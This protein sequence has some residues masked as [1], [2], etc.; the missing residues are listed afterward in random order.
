MGYLKMRSSHAS[1]RILKAYTKAT[2]RCSH[3]SIQMI[4]TITY[5]LKTESLKQLAVK[6]VSRIIHSK[7][8][9]RGKEP[10]IACIQ[11]IGQ[12]VVSS[13]LPLQI[14]MSASDFIL[15]PW[16]GSIP[17]FPYFSYWYPALAQVHKLGTTSDLQLIPHSSSIS[18]Q[19]GYCKQI[20]GLPKLFMS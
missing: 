19:M 18:L 17:W 14:N 11:I 6:M 12:P 4:S 16:T 1:T 2:S 20:N 15:F 9:G 3:T 10:P 7:D 5:S 8:V 13:W